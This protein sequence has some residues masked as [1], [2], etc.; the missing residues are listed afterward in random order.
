MPRKFYGFT[1]YQKKFRFTCPCGSL[2]SNNHYNCSKKFSA[3]SKQRALAPIDTTMSFFNYF[4]Y[5]SCFKYYHNHQFQIT[6]LIFNLI[7][8]YG[9][10][11]YYLVPCLNQFLLFKYKLNYEFFK[12]KINKKLKCNQLVINNISD[13]N[14]DRCNINF[15]IISNIMKIKL[16]F[17]HIYYY[18]FYNKKLL[19]NIKNYKFQLK[20]NY[21]IH[22]YELKN[23]IP[24][25]T[26]KYTSSKISEFPTTKPRGSLLNKLKDFIHKAKE[27]SLP[28]P[29]PPP[30][31]NPFDIKHKYILDGYFSKVKIDYHGP[32]PIVSYDDAV[33]KIEK[34][35]PKKKYLYYDRYKD[36][37][38]YH[39][40]KKGHTKALC[41]DFVDINDI[42][43]PEIYRLAKFVL[44]RP[45]RNILQRYGPYSDI[46]WTLPKV[47]EDLAQ[48]TQ[49]FWYEYGYPNPFAD[50]YKYWLFGEHRGR[51]IGFWWS[52]GTGKLYLL[53]LIVGYESKYCCKLPRMQLLNHKSLKEHYKEVM[54]TINDYI[55]MGICKIIP[56]NKAN[57]IM[58]MSAIVK[59]DGNGGTKTRLVLDAKC[60]NHYI[61]AMRFKPDK[62]ELVK[63]TVFKGARV[64]TQDG[65]KAFFQLKV[66]PRQALDQCVEIFHESLG[67]ITLAF[68]TVIFGGKNSCYYF[69]KMEDQLTRF[70]ILMGIKL[71][72]F[73]DDS[74]FY[75]QNSL[76]SSA[77]LGSFIKY[78]YYKCG[79]LLNETKTDLIRGSHTYKFCGFF[80]NSKLMKF[81]PLD[82]LISS[83]IIAI[84]YVINHYN[85]I[86]PIKKLVTVIGKLM[87]CGLAIREMSVLLLPL[88]EIMRSF[89]RK[90]GNEDIWFKRFK[91]DQYLCNH[92]LYLKQFIINDNIVPIVIDSWDVDIITDVSDRIAGSYDSDGFVCTIPL[93]VELRKA[94]SCLREAYGIFVA[95]INRLEKL[96]GKTVRILVD[97]LGTATVVMRNGSKIYELNQLVYQIVRICADNNIRL[98]VR[99]LRRDIQAIQFADDLSKSVEVDRW[100][101]NIDLFYHLVGLLKTPLPTL[102]LLADNENAIASNY[103]SRFHDGYSSGV[104]W[105][106][107]KAEFFADQIGYLNPPFRGDYLEV[108]IQ[109]IIDRQ[110][111]T[112]VLLPFWPTAPWYNKLISEAQIIVYIPDGTKYFQSPSYYTTRISKKWDVLLVLFNYK[113][114]TR[115][116]YRYN[117]LLNNIIS[118]PL[119]D[120]F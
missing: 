94:S 11:Y 120:E 18:K 53:K 83:S 106:N 45:T 43:D 64:C 113:K 48:A 99:W 4:L 38:C 20:N 12:F 78:V 101:F 28:Y 112:Y 100:L 84:E 69:K 9:E 39:C 36:I 33:T 119:V 104:N 105:M 98:W 32:P 115:K 57:V 2:L 51:D 107:K 19:Q 70:F 75:A 22:E 62:I 24:I 80:W 42:E 1:Y 21:N 34:L 71:N 73:Y 72:V 118:V 30:Y 63:S 90:Y 31:Y 109:Y 13:T 103:L 76:L 74:I 47:K 60:I 65:L 92:L 56:K 66:P 77:V 35:Y 5:K 29:K 8:I 49:R 23:K 87:Y 61:P 46:I 102:D 110:I 37:V 79:R 88:K 55:S 108:A 25:P 86:I 59:P 3:L 96:K 91:V 15:R 58:P 95:I 52:L 16:K 81:R 116:Y 54:E 89:H 17:K 7:H 93:T 10:Q 111:L 40:H 117:E 114:Q 82:K 26:T 27:Y 6:N 41:E 97:N 44:N 85:C 67:W 50:V 14:I 68:C